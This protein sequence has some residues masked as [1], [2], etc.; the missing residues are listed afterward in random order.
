MLPV[1]KKCIERPKYR[2]SLSLFYV[3]FPSLPQENRRGFLMFSGG[4]EREYLLEMD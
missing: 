4:T 3:N 1:P 2:N